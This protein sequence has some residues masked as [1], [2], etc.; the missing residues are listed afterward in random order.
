MVCQI[1]R[2]MSSSS[3]RNGRP[4]N[5]AIFPSSETSPPRYRLRSRLIFASTPPVAEAKIVPVS[6]DSLVVNTPLTFRLTDLP[7]EL[8]TMIYSHAIS[9]GTPQILCTSKQSLNEALHLICSHGKFIIKIESNVSSRY[10]DCDILRI[11][12]QTLPMLTVALKSRNIE[13]VVDFENKVKHKSNPDS[14]KRKEY[15]ALD[16][17]LGFIEIPQTCSIIVKN[18][19][20]NTRLSLARDIFQLMENMTRWE[21]VFLT[22]VREC[23]SENAGAEWAGSSA[24][25]GVPRPGNQMMY[26]YAEKRIMNALG[27]AV[28]HDS[29]KQESCYMAFRPREYQAH[30]TQ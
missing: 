20:R 18:V 5:R 26:M 24:L 2:N 28:W 23:G 14:L 7:L 9:S 1:A 3:Q 27:P 4:A 19:G 12:P 22:C 21:N 15:R 11:T 17:F 8:R 6:D 13:I 30:L 10:P 25:W 29:E 16:A